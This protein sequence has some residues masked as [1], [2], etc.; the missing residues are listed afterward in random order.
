MRPLWMRSPVPDYPTSFGASAAAAATEAQS[1]VWI[2]QLR[3]DYA[4]QQAQ[5]QWQSAFERYLRA[6]RTLQNLQA[7]CR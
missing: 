4:V 3:G 1:N 5:S 6:S 2:T 7:A